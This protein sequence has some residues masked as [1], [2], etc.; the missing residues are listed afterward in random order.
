MKTRIRHLLA[1]GLFASSV[2][3]Q[4][5]EVE[6][7][8]DNLES[9]NQEL[10]RR[11]DVLSTELEGFELGDLFLPVGDSVY[12]LGPSASKIYRKDQGISIGGYGEALYE[13][14]NGGRT[15]EFDFVRSV[16]YFGYKY[17]D[18]WVFNSEIEFE[19]ASTA[20]NGSVSVEFAYLDYLYT[21]AVNFR[22]GMVLVPMGFLNELHEPSTFLGATRPLTETRIMPS[23]WREN[24]VGVFGDA[25]PISY[26]SYIVNGFDGMDFS[27]SG[28]RGGRQRGSEALAEDL[29][30]V[31]RADW[32]DT[33]GFLAGA[34]VYYGNAGQDQAGLGST[35]TMVY[36][37]HAE[38]K[39]K[40]WW[41]RALAAMAEVDDVAELNA[42]NGFV[43]NQ[44]VGEELQGYYLEAAYDVM[45]LLDPE[46][47]MSIYPYVRWE[48]VDTQAEV[49]TGFASNPANDVEVTTLGLNIQPLSSI[50]FKIE[51]QDFDDGDD[52]ANFSLGYTF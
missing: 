3:A 8:L 25:G 47:Q 46:S 48:N 7:R 28:L 21:D 5:P 34:S 24:G 52:Q 39:A 29:A 15:D 2:Q 51:F 31:A 14:R 36:E 38:Y 19:H 50:V 40:G 11:I 6:E 18:N 41:L 33:P 23:T 20:A 45:G 35:G 10:R 22:G 9:E 13:R 12:G 44:S 37:A 42:A 17:N 26:R 4:S 30:F 27:A 16:L 1:L 32:T 43:G 49:P